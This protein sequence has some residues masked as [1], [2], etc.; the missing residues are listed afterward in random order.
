MSGIHESQG[1]SVG[2][3]MRL[4][5]NAR[6]WSRRYVADRAGIHHTTWSRLE[7]G[8]RGAD[9]RYMIAKIAAA[10][11][12]SVAELTGQPY[13]LPADTRAAE[14]QAGTTAVR[15]ALVETDLGEPPTCTPSPI[16]ALDQLV[17]ALRHY[18]RRANDLA[19]I[20]LLPGL[21]RELHSA[22]HT[23]DRDQALTLLTQVAAMSAGTMRHVGTE[24]DMWL[25]SE[26]C[27]QAAM[28]SGDPVLI[29]LSGYER[30]GAAI[31]CGSYPRGQRLASRALDELRPH[32]GRAG[33]LEVLGMLLL[34]CSFAAAGMGR[35]DDSAT[36]LVEAMGIATRTGDT[37]TFG[38]YWGPTNVNFWRVAMATDGGDPAQAV[39]IARGT[40]PTR[41]GSIS[42]QGDFYATTARA[43]VHVGGQD[44]SAVRWLLTA[45]RLIPY[46][47]R[48]N[49]LTREAT[50][51]LLERSDRTGTRGR[52]V[53][54]S[55]R[56]ALPV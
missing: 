11:E 6:G 4:R 34:T 20:H 52:I 23:G 44:A 45:E 33:G 10:L 26:R 47:V 29:A 24:G 31:R 37:D 5:R 50:R 53:A 17:I 41:I 19:T 12:C 51:T 56:M 48:T 9:N 22:T 3:Q 28:T 40:D 27:H 54:L 16:T 35:P 15:L 2:A 46:R 14:A 30:A 21:L 55:E 7:R 18:R 32:A 8:E 25:A 13:L 42:R 49:V 38:L 39:S 1:T 43:L 36:C